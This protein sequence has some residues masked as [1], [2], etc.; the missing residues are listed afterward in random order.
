MLT[1]SSSITSSKYLAGVVVADRYLAHK[2]NLLLLYSPT[3]P[4]NF[5]GWVVL[6][7]SLYE[8][9]GNTV[10]SVSIVLASSLDCVRIQLNTTHTSK[11]STYIYPEHSDK[12]WTRIE[13]V[14][15]CQLAFFY[16]FL[17]HQL[18]SNSLLFARCHLIIICHS[19]YV[20]SVWGSVQ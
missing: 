2:H 7:M 13:F 5:S 18:L 20:T 15:L 12:N 19:L 6:A 14:N 4:C 3:K 17:P 8:R 9:R 10:K 1:C 11:A 16:G